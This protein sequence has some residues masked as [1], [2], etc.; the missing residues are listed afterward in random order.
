MT[1]KKIDIGYE[2]LSNCYLLADEQT[3]QAA[4]IDPGAYD[5]R[6]ETD[7]VLSQGGYLLKYILLTHGHFDHILGAYELRKK[8]DAKLAIHAEDAPCLSD[9]HLSLA[10]ENGLA[11]LQIP[12]SPDILLRDGDTLFL[13]ENEIRVIHTPG[14]T[15]GG[16]CYVVEG[17]RTVFTGDTLFCMTV[18]RTD[19]DGGSI[20][21]L[22]ASIKKLLE[23]QGDYRILPGHNME[24]TLEREKTR[25]RFIRR[26]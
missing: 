9:A 26:M 10:Q 20:R 8:Y 16:V 15:R 4:V 24:T 11:E 18:G 22:A 23:L 21:E 3:K 14:H 5:E 1:I 6:S 13:G 25:N 12:L 17:E 2:Q 19:F 7:A